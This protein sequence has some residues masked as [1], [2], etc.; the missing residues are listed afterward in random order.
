MNTKHTPG[1]WTVTANTTG[2]GHHVS[3][4]ESRWAQ[5]V[6]V[7]ASPSRTIEA[8]AN[9]RLIAAAPE[10]LE[11]LLAMVESYEYEASSKNP[12]L[13]QAREAITKA[14]NA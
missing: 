13:L 1:P 5:M 8:E 11:A 7:H 3:A 2:P 9:A 14:T 4:F 10:L 12:V 6:T